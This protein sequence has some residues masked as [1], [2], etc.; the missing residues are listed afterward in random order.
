M[1]APSATPQIDLTQPVRV[2][3]DLAAAIARTLSR[4]YPG[5]T[6]EDVAGQLAEPD[7]SRDVIGWFAA[8][9]LEDALGKHL[10]APDAD[11]VLAATARQS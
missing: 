11:G 2:T 10:I 5:T 4:P 3:P 6:A 7:T 8:D 9:S 1:D